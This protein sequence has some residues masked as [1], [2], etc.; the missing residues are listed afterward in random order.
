MSYNIIIAALGSDAEGVVRV[1]RDEWE[2]A[3]LRYN[4]ETFW[5]WN[6]RGQFGYEADGPCVF[7]EFS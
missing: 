3:K 6:I 5:A 2:P 1:A 4:L 7:I